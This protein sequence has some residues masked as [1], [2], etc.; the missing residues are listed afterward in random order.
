MENRPV[1]V[2]M[3]ALDHLGPDKGTFRDNAF[4]RHHVVEMA[5]AECA[6]VAGKLSEATNVGT[7]VHLI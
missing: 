1:F 4:E 3:H 5:R 2:V 7:V 6:R